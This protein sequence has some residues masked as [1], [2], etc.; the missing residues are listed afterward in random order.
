MLVRRYV[1]LHS[2]R[3]ADLIAAIDAQANKAEAMRAWMRAGLQAQRAAGTGLDLEAIAAVVRAALRS[4]LQGLRLQAEDVA[5]GEPA[6]EAKAKLR[7][8][9]RKVGT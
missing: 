8:M 6:E 7:E 3:D 4:E 2:E 1:V 9:F 5:R